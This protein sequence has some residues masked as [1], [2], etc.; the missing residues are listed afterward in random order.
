MR[1][2]VVLVAAFLAVAGCS[3]DGVPSGELV[4]GED[5][6]FT[7][8]TVSPTT[9]DEGLVFRAFGTITNLTDVP[10][11]GPVTLT[12]SQGPPCPGPT[13]AELAGDVDIEAGAAV[14]IELTSDEAVEVEPTSDDTSRW[15]C[16][17]IRIDFT[18]DAQRD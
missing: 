1:L 2:V 9:T 12:V 11:R 7:D 16:Q 13:V 4:D 3:D 10:V 15:G 17:D 14:E 18:H 6:T 5:F 8:V